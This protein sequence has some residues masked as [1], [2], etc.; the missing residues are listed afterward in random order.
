MTIVVGTSTVAVDEGVI[1]VTFAHTVPAGKGRMLTVGISFNNDDFEVVDS[2]TF[3]GVNAAFLLAATEEDDSRTELWALY[4]PP[5]TT[6][7]IVVTMDA[8]LVSGRGIGI[9]ALNFTGVAKDDQIGASGTNQEGFDDAPN[10]D[11]TSNVGEMVVDIYGSEDGSGE[12]TAAAV[13]QTEY[14]NVVTDGSGSTIMLVA[15]STKPAIAVST[16]MEWLQTFEAEWTLCAATLLPSVV[17]TVDAGG[18]YS[19]DF[20]TPIALAATVT[21]G[22]DVAPTYAWTIDSG[23]G[24][25]IFLPSAAVEDPTFTPDA[26]GAY[27]LRLTVVTEDAPDVFDTASLDSQVV[28]PSVDAGANILDALKLVPRALAGVVTPGSDPSPTILWDIQVDAFTPPGGSS[29]LD[30]SDPTTDFTPGGSQSGVLR[31]TA[32]PSDG[33][34]VSDT[35]IFSVPVINPVVDAGG[36]YSGN[37]NTPIA[38]TATVTTPG[39]NPVDTWEWDIISGG[40]GYFTP[41]KFVQN[42]SFIPTGAGAYVLEVKGTASVDGGEGTDTANLQSNAVGPSGPV[43]GNVGIATT[44]LGVIAGVRL[45]IGDPLPANT[46]HLAGSALTPEGFLLFVEDDGLVDRVFINGLPHTYDGVRILTADS[47]EVVL[48]GWGLTHAGAQSAQGTTPPTQYNKGFGLLDDGSLSGVEVSGGGGAPPALANLEH[49]F[50]F[51]D[52]ATLF[53]DVNGTTPI[54]SLGEVIR[55]ISNKGFSTD[56]PIQAGAGPEFLTS[57]FGLNGQTAGRFES[58]QSLQT[59]FTNGS[60]GNRTFA[61]IFRN[62]QSASPAQEINVF[63]WGATNNFRAYITGQVSPDPNLILFQQGGGIQNTEVAPLQSEGYWAINAGEPFTGP[64]NMSMDAA[65]G[66]RIERAQTVS[67]IPAAQNFVLGPNIASVE[68]QIYEVLIWNKRLSLAEMDEF[69][70]YADARYG[71]L[72]VTPQPLKIEDL[73]HWFDFTDLTTLWQNAAGTVPVVAGT[74]IERVDDKGYAGADFIDSF[75]PGPVWQPSLI[76]GLGGTEQL[77]GFPANLQNAAYPNDADT[78][79]VQ[80]V[81]RALYSGAAANNIYL[82]SAAPGVLGI[83]ADDTGSGDWAGNVTNQP[84]PTSTG[85]PITLNEWVRVSAGQ[86]GGGGDNIYSAS[87]SPDVVLTGPATAPG[88]PSVATLAQLEGNVME[89]LVY[90]EGMDADERQA[91]DDNYF[92]RRYGTLP[93]S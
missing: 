65:A 68:L 79:F 56:N 84:Q 16:H 88:T 3:D 87:G 9:G 6:A 63:N 19:G 52:Q 62:E 66:V 42:P 59:T 34:P 50:D 90:D 29:F 91:Q 60:N 15:G 35:M 31:L 46:V 81:V 26:A 49:W 69:E 43:H 72:P 7:N 75:P 32:T 10:I 23:P 71:V 36:L 54:S 17:P 30:D 76:N 12:S 89:V 8:Q 47:P 80:A 77:A 20:G 51:T 61:V 18:P 1:S 27:T 58:N 40:G 37:V 53:A 82:S 92:N 57:P 70:A 13:G 85:R 55:R 4:N 33:P 93:H 39:T 74:D 22:T 21:P 86:D 78:Q 73:V 41:N 24:G 5:V 48:G 28:P 44:N 14:I 45:E 11:I 83:E 2:V 67:T 64:D 25:G 38:L